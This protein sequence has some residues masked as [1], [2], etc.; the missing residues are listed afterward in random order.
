MSPLILKDL[1][2]PGTFEQ[3]GAAGFRLGFNMAYFIYT[4]EP[5]LNDQILRDCRSCRLSSQRCFIFPRFSKY[6]DS[7]YHYII[8]VKRETDSTVQPQIVRWVCNFGSR[9]GVADR[10]R[11][12]A[13]ADLRNTPIIISVK[14][15]MD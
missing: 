5:F 7:D 4:R 3:A 14:I 9:D 10:L 12:I 13:V 6:S 11:I 8:S 15:E 2:H 1:I